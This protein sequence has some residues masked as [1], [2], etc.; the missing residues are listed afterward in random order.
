LRKPGQVSLERALSKL[1][2]ASRTEARKW[3]LAG[4]VRVNG[5]Q[6]QSPNFPVT[7]E[8]AKIEIEGEGVQTQVLQTRVFLLFKPRGVVTTHSD[9]KGRSTV[10]SL[11]QSLD[12]HLIAVGRLDWATSGLL[13]LTNDTQL[14]AWLTDPLNQVVRTYLV[15]V[16]G[17]VTDSELAELTS[18][19][20]I[21]DRGEI[22]RS[23]SVVLR[24]SSSKES[25]LVV[26]LSEGKNRE[27]RRMFLKL[28][29][30]VTALKR[31][32]YG[33]IGLGILK[34]GE[35]REIPFGELKEA[36]PGAVYKRSPGPCRTA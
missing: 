11:I 17:L 7:P 23:E 27:I 30:E 6:R 16:R 25:H 28:G 24:K 31:V 20:G 2:I 22:L 4:R 26:R 19:T 36:F 21:S 3:I 13:L 12:L 33:P 14:A 34:P 5:V 35:F 10:F 15:T 32:N 8:R 9:E 1:G 18:Q 29:H